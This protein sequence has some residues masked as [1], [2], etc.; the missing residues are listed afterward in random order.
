MSKR[1][2]QSENQAPRGLQRPPPEAVVESDNILGA[3][4]ADSDA[5]EEAQS[6]PDSETGDSDNQSPKRKSRGRDRRIKRLT[7]RAAQAE[8]ALDDERRRSAELEAELER[9]RS[10]A[11]AKKPTM[12]DYD[13]EEEYA[14][15]YAEWKASQTPKTTPRKKK[16]QGPPQEELNAFVEAGGEVMGTAWE[17]A[18]ELAK[19]DKFPLNANM[20]EY[21]LDSDH[22]HAMFV[23][24]SKKPTLAREIAGEKGHAALELLQDLEDEI[25]SKPAKEEKEERPRDKQGKFKKTPP[26]PQRLQSTPSTAGSTAYDAIPEMDT[27]GRARAADLRS[28]MQRRR[29]YHNK[30]PGTW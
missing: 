4:G 6:T 12:R 5:S 16:V 15:A 21:L 27:D 7:R 26:G 23:A 10:G 20:M 19:A 11:Q 18:M 3:D 22:G 29:D 24:L 9:V 8:E 28:F 2:S 30:N 13:S 25:A 17:K 14:E 1:D